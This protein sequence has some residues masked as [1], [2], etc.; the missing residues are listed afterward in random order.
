MA[1]SAKFT[2]F[3]AERTQ[4]SIAAKQMLL[5]DYS[6]FNALEQV[7]REC[8]RA[9][10]AN[11]KLFFFGNGG[12]AA[13]AQHL[14]AELV[15]RFKRER[16]GWAALALTVNSSSLTAIANDYSFDH[17]F[18]RQVEALGVAGDVAVAISTSGNSISVLRGVEAARKYGMVSV[19]LTGSSGGKLKDVT[20]YCIRVPSDDTARIQEV[21]ILLGHILCDY[22]EQELCADSS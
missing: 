14:A 11:R 17:V 5:Q 12:S 2:Q 1:L 22:L 15:G 3:A 8:K 4:Q 20:D 6:V 21:H 7:A 9:L 13:D 18:A 10:S 19:G 16:R